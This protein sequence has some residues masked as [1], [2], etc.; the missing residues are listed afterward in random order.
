MKGTGKPFVAIEA[1]ALLLSRQD[2]TYKLYKLDDKLTG[3]VREFSGKTTPQHPES[4]QFT[5]KTKELLRQA[6]EDESS[7]WMR[8]PPVGLEAKTW[9][10]TRTK[11]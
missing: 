3:A 11:R 9:G 8:P 1:Q 6:V 2:S 10:P 4:L 7:V 5:K